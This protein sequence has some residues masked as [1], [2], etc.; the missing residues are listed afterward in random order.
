MHSRWV[1]SA[2]ALVNVLRRVLRVARIVTL[3]A[4]PTLQLK[5]CGIF[6]KESDA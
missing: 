1:L 3:F 5:Q 2:L 6:A 4:T